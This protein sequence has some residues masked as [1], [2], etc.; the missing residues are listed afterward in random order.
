MFRARECSQ[1]DT[2]LSKRDFLRESGIKWANSL[3]T[4]SI[5]WSHAGKCAG[6][7][8]LSICVPW[9]KTEVLPLAS[10]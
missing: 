5:V 8:G 4:F 9:V 2:E 1:Y 7:D 6:G 10:L 3:L